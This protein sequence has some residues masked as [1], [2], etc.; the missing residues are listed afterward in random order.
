MLAGNVPAIRHASTPLYASA[1][2]FIPTFHKQLFTSYGRCPTTRCIGQELDSYL[3]SINARRH[4]GFPAFVCLVLRIYF[5]SRSTKGFKT[6]SSNSAAD[7]TEAV[8]SLMK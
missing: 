8:V 2:N 1:R 6:S 3:R 4:I 7:L 5:E